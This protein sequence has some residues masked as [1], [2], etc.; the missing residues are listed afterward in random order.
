MVRYIPVKQSSRPVGFGYLQILNLLLAVGEGSLDV[1]FSGR[2]LDVK[3]RTSR[4]CINDFFA[5]AL[6]D[7][8]ADVTEI[9]ARMIG[10]RKLAV[11]AVSLRLHLIALIRADTAGHVRIALLCFSFNDAAPGY[12]P[13]KLRS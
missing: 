6:V 3:P 7:G 2:E 9:L 4:R 11:V 10:K 1:V 12:F 13:C 5:T 8:D